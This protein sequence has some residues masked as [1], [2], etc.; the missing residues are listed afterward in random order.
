MTTKQL[1]NGDNNIYDIERIQYGNMKF[2]TEPLAKLI[3][4]DSGVL[5]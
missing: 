2:D 3:H 1:T 5:K 4:S